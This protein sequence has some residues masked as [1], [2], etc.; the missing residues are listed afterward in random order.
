MKRILIGLALAMGLAIVVSAQIAVPNTLTAGST[1]KAADLNTNFTTIANHSLDRLS[2]GLISGNITVAAGVTIDGVDIGATVCATCSPTF[3]D[4]TLTS[5]STGITVAGN[6]VVTSAGKV[7]ATQLVGTVPTANLGSGTADS[8]TFLRGDQTYAIP[9]PAGTVIFFDGASCPAG[10]AE[11]TAARGRY[12]VGKPSGGTLDASVGTA[13]T[14]QEN[15]ATGVH[16]HTA[17]SSTPTASAP[18]VNDPGHSHNGRLLTSPLA[19]FSA[20][21]GGYQSASSSGTSGADL[22]TTSST[23]GITVNAPTISTPTI[24]VNNSTGVAGTN[25]PYYQLL[26]CK[27]S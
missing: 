26:V 10:F 24:T 7:D 22:F 13:L 16:S 8:T 15:R 2:G 27:K 19:G 5:P 4:L 20:P 3:K 18:T 14:D 6:T 21:S 11:L 1:I 12:L 23:T 9:V 17:T 25:A